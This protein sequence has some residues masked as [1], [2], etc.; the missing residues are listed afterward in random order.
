MV[1]KKMDVIKNSELLIHFFE[2]SSPSEQERINQIII[3]ICGYSLDTIIYQPN[4][5]KEI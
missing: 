2:K 3:C 5:I 4:L 1:N